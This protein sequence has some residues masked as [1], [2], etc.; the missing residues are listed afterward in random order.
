M[1]IC[2]TTKAETTRSIARGHNASERDIARW[3]GEPHRGLLPSG[4]SV[5]LPVGAS[6]GSAAGH[7]FP[8]ISEGRSEILLCKEEP[9]FLGSSLSN[10]CSSLY[11][12]RS[13]YLTR[14]GFSRLHACRARLPV[15]V[16][17]Q[18]YTG[19]TFS[20]GA[21]SDVLLRYGYAGLLLPL[22]ATLSERLL[23]SLPPL[24]LALAAHGL[25]LALSLS[26]PAFSRIL[27]HL[28]SLTP[29]PAFF[30]L[31]PAIPEEPLEARARRVS[32][33]TDGSLRRRILFS[34]PTGATL[35]VHE[36][37]APLT[38]R[39]ALHI[40]CTVG[41]PPRREEVLMA[42]LP[43]RMGGGTLY[44]EDPLSFYVGLTRL[45]LSGFG[46]V[47]LSPSSAPFAEEMI[48][49]LFTVAGGTG[50]ARSQR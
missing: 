9:D 49:R 21:L 22:G 37:S 28:A 29:L 8:P 12:V 48:R 4:I 50:A 7:V 19:E 14:R 33:V 26:D 43:P 35:I 10:S 39:E 27:P 47:L 5:L 44:V 15:F 11:V 38:Y 46:G 34:I 31:A 2:Q 41:V 32:D 17:P 23:A 13:G 24:A 42:S 25:H 6:G 40:L 18:V 16:S 3:A 30:L 20:P 1:R 45:G 36:K